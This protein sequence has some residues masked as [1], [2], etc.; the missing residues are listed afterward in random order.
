MKSLRPLATIGPRMDWTMEFAVQ[1][2]YR[3]LSITCHCTPFSHPAA[4]RTAHV[5]Q[6]TSPLPMYVIILYV[7]YFTY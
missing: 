3:P 4:I 5:D 7:C 1:L 6:P 2:L